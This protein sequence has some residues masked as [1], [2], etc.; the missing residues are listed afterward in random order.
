MR[1]L[2]IVLLIF[3]L[4][5]CGS[6][7]SSNLI[8]SF[9]TPSTVITALADI[10]VENETGKKVSEHALSFVTSKDCKFNLKDM[11]ICK[12]ENLTNKNTILIKYN[13]KNYKKINVD[14]LTS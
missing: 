2:F 7:V 3:S 10:R 9:L 8:N 12:D 11:T 1:A 4:N 6:L 14:T 5:S 13:K